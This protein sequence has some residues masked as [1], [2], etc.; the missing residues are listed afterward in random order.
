MNKNNYPHKSYHEHKGHYETDLETSISSMHQRQAYHIVED[1]NRDPGKKIIVPNA[2][3][4]PHLTIGVDVGSGYGWLSEFMTITKGYEKVYAIE[5][6]EKAMEVAKRDTNPSANI[7]WVT[8][9]AEDFLNS[10]EF[11]NKVAGHA[12]P[13]HFWFSFVLTHLPN[14]AVVPICKAIANVAPPGSIVSFEE[15]Y[16]TD[17]QSFEHAAHCFHVRTEQWWRSLFPGWAVQFSGMNHGSP[18]MWPNRN[19]SKSFTFFH[20]DM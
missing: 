18:D 10:E 7:E 19:L 13:I 3:K 9:F 16:T 17:D 6:V 4:Y 2:E 14:E 15:C 1:V 20:P 8:E 5:P 11:A 12:K